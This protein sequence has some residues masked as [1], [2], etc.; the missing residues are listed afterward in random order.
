MRAAVKEGAVDPAT[1]YRMS[2][3]PSRD[4]G[5]ELEVRRALHRAG[6]R[7]RLHAAHLP[8]CPDI[9]LPRSRTAVFVHG[10]F[11]HG[12][13]CRRARLP[14][15]NTSYWERKIRRTRER[16]RTAAQA[17]AERGWK[18]QVIWACEIQAGIRGLIRVLEETGS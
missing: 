4:T 17:L 5:P 15:R 11:W 6:Y 18:R 10:C 8:G 3:V 16:D 14:R 12:H 13:G 7:F 9:V 2:R 1:S